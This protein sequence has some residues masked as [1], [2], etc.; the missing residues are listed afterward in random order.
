MKYFENQRK[1]YQETQFKAIHK[2]K[3]K[4]F[5]Y[6]SCY[7]FS[8]LLCSE[9]PYGYMGAEVRREKAVSSSH[10]EVDREDRSVN[11]IAGRGED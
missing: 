8:S 4:T 3:L 9:M 11:F 7:T 2:L 1:I 6:Y 10:G 5:K